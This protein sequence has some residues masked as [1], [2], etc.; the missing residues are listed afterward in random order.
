MHLQLVGVCL[1]ERDHLGSM[2]LKKF[3]LQPGVTRDGT[4]YSTQGGWWATQWMRFHLGIAETMNGFQKNSALADPNQSAYSTHYQGVARA[5][6]AWTATDSTP[7]LAIGTTDH[8]YIDGE[9]YVYDVTPVGL[10]TSSNSQVYG[11]GYG[12]AT[13]SYGPYSASILDTG[14]AIDFSMRLW[15]QANWGNDLIVC[16]KDMPNGL[17]YW[18]YSHAQFEWVKNPAYDPVTNPGVPPYTAPARPAK[19]VT[20]A[21]M[22]APATCPYSARMIFVTLDQHVVALGASQSGSIL[23]DLMHVWWSNYQAPFDWDLTG[24]GTGSTDAG[25]VRLAQGSY[26]VSGRATRLENLIWTDTALYSMKYIGAGYIYGFT[27]IAANIT[28]ASQNSTVDN[29]STVFWMGQGEFY[30]YSGAVDVLP[31][32]VRDYVFQNINYAY[33]PKFFGGLNRAYAE[34]WFFYCSATSTE[35]NSYVVYNWTENLWYF[36]TITRSA[37]LDPAIGRLPVAAATGFLYNHESGMD[38]AGQPLDCFLE[39]SDLDIAD[40]QHFVFC[41][42]AIPDVQFMLPQAPS[43][44][45]PNPQVT[46]TVNFKPAPNGPISKTVSAAYLKNGSII[47]VRGRGRAAAFRVESNTTG[48]FWRVGAMRFD[49]EPDGRR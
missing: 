19:L 13:Y 32:P 9:G 16:D 29:G 33:A 48:Q 7:L 23:P 38:A 8:Y 28:I 40:G 41:R 3:A 46:V 26:I 1:E 39:S 30:A 10:P 21:S 25:D 37:W 5:L 15:S 43:N 45:N 2:A 22:H 44:P 11:T 34:I 36:G 4:Q 49:V 27:L 42:R 17:Y 12:T 31:C 14:K 18:T 47:Y 35:V 20:L 6:F 24:A